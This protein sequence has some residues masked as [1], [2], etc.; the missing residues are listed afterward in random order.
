MQGTQLGAHPHLP[1]HATSAHCAQMFFSPRHRSPAC[2]PYNVP[3]AF[4]GAR[5][6]PPSQCLLHRLRIRIRFV[7]GTLFSEKTC[8]H[9]PIALDLHAKGFQSCTCPSMHSQCPCPPTMQAALHPLLCPTEPRAALQWR[10]GHQLRVLS[11]EHVGLSGA[12]GQWGESGFNKPPALGRASE[13]GGSAISPC[14]SSLSPQ[15]HPSC[16]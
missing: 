11:W 2:M 14:I 7:H 5:P 8:F 12:V 3:S 6:L 13:K 9:H 1:P 15:S 10:W 16:R 4:L